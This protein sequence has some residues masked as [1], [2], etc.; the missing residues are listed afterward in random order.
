MQM[1]MVQAGS[2]SCS[3]CAAFLLNQYITRAPKESKQLGPR[4]GV[5]GALAIGMSSES[6]ARPRR[7]RAVFQEIQ[8][9]PR[10][11]S[12]LGIAFE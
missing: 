3:A 1:H 11:R 7:P 9:R 5:A 4:R 10:G 2:R 6:R 8:P 12:V